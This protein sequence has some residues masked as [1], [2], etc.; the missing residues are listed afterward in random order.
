MSL[1]VHATI[2]FSVYGE[3]VYKDSNIIKPAKQK[4]ENGDKKKKKKENEKRMKKK[5]KVS[6]NN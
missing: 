2:Y 1:R 3:R 6:K 5:E 4:E